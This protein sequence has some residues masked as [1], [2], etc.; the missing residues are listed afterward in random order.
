MLNFVANE[1]PILNPT[2]WIGS[3]EWR[4]PVT[5]LTDLLTAIVCFYAFLQFKKYQGNKSTSFVNYQYYFLFF[6]ISML[7]AAW[8]G[9][10]LQAYFGFDW[11]KI[12]WVMSSIGFILI[13]FATIKELKNT[14]KPSII[15]FFKTAFIIQFIVL[16]SL[17]VY[18]QN[19]KIPQ[20]NSTITFILFVLPLQVFAYIK[21]KKTGHLIVLGTIAFAIIPGLVYNNQLSFGKWFNYHDISHV[22]MALFMFLMFKGTSKLSFL[23][24]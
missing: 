10:G 2:L 3:F 24:R 9:H 5:T 4:E 17:M 8:F 22:L 6:S 12:G 11:K 7:S 18:Y 14:L 13:E 19:F 20:L 21:S 23:K 15:N 1:D 16:V